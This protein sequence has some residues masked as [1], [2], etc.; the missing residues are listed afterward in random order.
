MYIKFHIQ[1]HEIKYFKILS[2]CSTFDSC[3]GD[4]FQMIFETW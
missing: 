3:D 4:N 1:N 2:I